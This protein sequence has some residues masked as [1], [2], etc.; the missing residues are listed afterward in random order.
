M[1]I[2]FIIV[3]LH[4]F[5]FAH[6]YFLFYHTDKFLSTRSVPEISKIYHAFRKIR[7]HRDLPHFFFLGVDHADRGHRAAFF[8][9]IIDSDHPV[10]LAYHITVALH[11]D[12]RPG[13]IGMGAEGTVV[14][15][16]PK[17]NDLDFHWPPPSS[18]AG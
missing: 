8:P 14:L 1:T 11:I 10:C 4:N 9:P 15:R 5:Q 2:L 6:L 12:I 18:A 17:I 3:V 13:V 7:P 16:Q